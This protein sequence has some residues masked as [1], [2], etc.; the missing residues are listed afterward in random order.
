MKM[1]TDN[2]QLQL[3]KRF[4]PGRELGVGLQRIFAH[5]VRCPYFTVRRAVRR[6]R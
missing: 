2:H 5:N 3:F 1:S 6:A 4:T